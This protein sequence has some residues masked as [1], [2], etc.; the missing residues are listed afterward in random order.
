MGVLCCFGSG[1]ARRVGT[2][3]FKICVAFIMRKK[4]GRSEVGFSLAASPL[5]WH[6]SSAARKYPC[7]KNA[8]A[9]QAIGTAMG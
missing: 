7:H 9:T 1:A 2:S 8:P 6:S 4:C 3:Q 5:L